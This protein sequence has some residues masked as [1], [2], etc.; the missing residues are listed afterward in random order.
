[1]LDLQTE[2]V[3]LSNRTEP[4]GQTSSAFRLESMLPRGRR[5]PQ[6]ETRGQGS[7]ARWLPR[8]PSGVPNH[9]GREKPIH[10]VQ[11]RPSAEVVARGG[12]RHDRL[13]LVRPIFV[14]ETS[15]AV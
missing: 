9:H 13:K 12:Q 1:M 8:L 14:V 7:A 4:N 15:G 6:A 5:D 3:M 10:R 11:V 2:P